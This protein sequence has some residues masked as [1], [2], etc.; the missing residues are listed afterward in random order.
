MVKV[1]LYGGGEDS[2]AVSIRYSFRGN[3]CLGSGTFFL[4][5]ISGSRDWDPE[6]KFQPKLQ[7]KS[8][9]LKAQRDYEKCPYL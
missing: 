7:K 5:K 3:R 4:R 9:A 1:N 6:A 2:G 8:F